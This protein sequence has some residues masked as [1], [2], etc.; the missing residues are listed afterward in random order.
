MNKTIRNTLAALGVGVILI[1]SNAVAWSDFGIKALHGQRPDIEV[2]FSPY[3]GAEHLIVDVINSSEKSVRLAAYSFTSPPIV[4]AL[5]DARKRG[6]D[7]QVIVDYDNN[8]GMKSGAAKA[9]LN[10]LVNNQI[11]VKLI[12]AY[13]IH[14]D[15]Y[16]VVDDKTVETGSFNYSKAAQNKNS[17]NILVLWNRPDIAHKYI[18]HWQDRFNGGSVYQSTY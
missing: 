18:A 17:E 2:A 5:V 12:T 15:K 14:H 4:K 10:L 1:S 13:A 3:E 11:P 8:I 7:V 16:I 6:V 9:A